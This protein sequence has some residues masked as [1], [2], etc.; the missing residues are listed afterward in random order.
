MILQLSLQC[1]AIGLETCLAQ[2]FGALFR[3]KVFA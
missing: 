2:L 1:V 3:N